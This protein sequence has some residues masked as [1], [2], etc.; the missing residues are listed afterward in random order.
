MSRWR[1]LET[2][3][4]VQAALAALLPM[5]ALA[6]FSLYT[7]YTQQVQAA[8]AAQRE[9]TKRAALLIETRLTHV[10]SLLQA[11]AEITDWSRVSPAERDRILRHLIH[12]APL[13]QEISLLDATGREMNRVSRIRLITSEDLRNLS[14]NE[15]FLKAKNGDVSWGPVQ[16]SANGAPLL[17]V[18]VPC[19]DPYGQRP[20]HYFMAVISLRGLWDQVTAFRVGKG[21]VMY[22]IDASGRLLAHPDYSLVLAETRIDEAPLMQAL[23]SGAPLPSRYRDAWNRPVMGNAQ[24]IPALGWWVVVEQPASEALAPVRTLFYWLLLGVMLAMTASA[25]PGWFI[26]R[27]VTHPI[28]LLSED[29]IA[30]GQGDLSRRSAIQ[31]QDEIGQLAR[32]FN[33]MVAELQQ[34]ASGLEGLVA[35][36]TEKLQVALEQAQEADRLKSAFLATVSHELRTPLTSIK[37]FA[38]TLLLEDVTWDKDTQQDFLRTIV[39]EADKLRDLVNQLLDMAQLEAGTLRLQRGPCSLHHLVSVTLERMQPLLGERPVHVDIPD[40][41]PPIDGDRERIIDI[42]RNLIENITKYTPEG[43][44]ITI[45]AHKVDD[46]IQVDIHDKGPGIPPEALPHLFERFYRGDH[47]ETSGTGLGLAICKGLVQAHGGRIWAESQIGEGST[48]H[49]TLPCIH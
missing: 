31:R 18:F 40:D 8:S 22:I 35:V 20:K 42:L 9:M 1:R 45:T 49:F 19:R 10:V 16:L 47:P 6:G 27:S 43:A 4:I 5:L 23:R 29:A 12:Q 2:R 14:G 24:A 36:R 15:A 46:M 34:Y 7:L 25:I 37:G 41:L 3:M 11:S 39:E 48:I 44:P 30:V 38:E 33:Q 32:A 28:T 17:T 13:A 21:G 26:A